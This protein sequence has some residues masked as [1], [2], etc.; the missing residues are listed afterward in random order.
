MNWS[1]ITPWYTLFLFYASLVLAAFITGVWEGSLLNDMR[2]SYLDA[3]S[4]SP[5]SDRTPE[6]GYES[7]LD[8]AKT[9]RALSFA[10][11]LQ[12]QRTLDPEKLIPADKVLERVQSSKPS[13]PMMRKWQRSVMLLGCSWVVIAGGLALHI[14]VASS[15]RKLEI[16]G[17][18]VRHSNTFLPGRLLLTCYIACV[19]LQRAMDRNIP[20]LPV[21]AILPYMAS[22]FSKT[23]RAAG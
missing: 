15:W 6:E 9:M 17:L 14:L 5:D 11:E 18:G 10:V 13:R 12:D 16:G 19:H 21:V 4:Q 1:H 8:S 2:R 3:F 23:C 22:E 7:E 20:I